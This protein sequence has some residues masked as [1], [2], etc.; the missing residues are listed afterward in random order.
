MQTLEPN[1]T[2]LPSMIK[3]LDHYS[4]RL[5]L[6]ASTAKSIPNDDFA[7]L[8]DGGHYYVLKRKNDKLYVWEPMGIPISTS[9]DSFDEQIHKW[10]DVC[11]Q[12]C[13]VEKNN[14]TL[15]AESSTTCGLYCTTLALYLNKTPVK[16][17]HTAPSDAFV[18][19]V[20]SYVPVASTLPKWFANLDHYS[21]ELQRN[22][23]QMIWYA[24]V[25]FPR[26]L[27]TSTTPKDFIPLPNT[28]V[29][30]EY[31]SKI[32]KNKLT[33]DVEMEENVDYLEPAE[34]AGGA[35]TVVD[36]DLLSQLD[37]KEMIY[38]LTNLPGRD[39]A[40]IIKEAPI[41]VKERIVAK[42]P[43]DR[44]KALARFNKKFKEIAKSSKTTTAEPPNHERLSR[45][46]VSHT[47]NMTLLYGKLNPKMKSLMYQL[48]PAKRQA[49][50]PQPKTMTPKTEANLKQ[51][52][53]KLSS[54][55]YPNHLLPKQVRNKLNDIEAPTRIVDDPRPKLTKPI[56]P[57]VIEDPIPVE[58][59][60][61]DE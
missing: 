20:S 47:G 7:V 11:Y 37:S 58:E 12:Y 35:K 39:A 59:D 29:A 26:L 18:D 17:W 42:L 36:A 25:I 56:I 45:K 28:T 24:S 46:L 55:N 60:G 1:G 48:L 13:A 23:R 50:F 30:P 21:L 41:K 14:S 4:I 54:L 9:Q 38:I 61:V 6:G 22:D 3:L 49:Q 15:T 44:W 57:R 33:K 51:L 19:I 8:L 52:I 34:L 53:I 27:S 16:I 10:A 32:R 2:N 5:C 43:A 31:E 40:R